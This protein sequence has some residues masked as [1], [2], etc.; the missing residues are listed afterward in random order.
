MSETPEFFDPRQTPERLF[1]TSR[2]WPSLPGLP[3]HIHSVCHVN[4]EAVDPAHDSVHDTWQLNTY[5]GPS[6]IRVGRRTDWVTRPANSVVLVPPQH[7]FFEDNGISNQSQ[8]S[9]RAWIAFSEAQSMGL[10]KF[11]QNKRGF[12]L[13]EDPEC[14]IGRFI[15]D[16]TASLAGKGEMGFWMA[17]YA[18]PALLP[19]LFA[20]KHVGDGHYRLSYKAPQILL[21]PLVPKTLEYLGDHIHEPVMVPQMAR[22]F[23][24]APSTLAHRYKTATG[25]SIM[26]TLK[27]LRIFTAKTLL[28]SGRK[29]DDV[30][31]ATGFCDRHHL[32]KVFRAVEGISPRY[33]RDQINDMRTR[34]AEGL[35]KPLPTESQI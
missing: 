17:Q 20:A 33:F 23:R 25:E 8:T 12:S 35:H 24:C 21:D 32:S 27:R 29:L 10:L 14:V 7:P 3:Y 1:W 6:R 11:V 4:T 15:V 5:F 26:T 2:I 18:F 30:A 19:V 16:L 9:H 13:F 22:A 31:G 28:M 34:L